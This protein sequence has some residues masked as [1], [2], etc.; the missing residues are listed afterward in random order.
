M[1]VVASV[2]DDRMRVM[3]DWE[4]RN[5]GTPI[6]KIKII[7]TTKVILACF[8]GICYLSLGSVLR[9]ALNP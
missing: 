4:Q 8:E 9:A 5:E 2:V 6:H 7:V 1:V 3:G